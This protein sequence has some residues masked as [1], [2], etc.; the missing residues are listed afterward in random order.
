M[1]Y[2][3]GRAIPVAS[4][5]YRIGY[6]T[7]NNTA[8]DTSHATTNLYQKNRYV[9]LPKDTSERVSIDVIMIGRGAGSGLPNHRISLREFDGTAL[10]SHFT[11]VTEGTTSGDHMEVV[12]G[13]TEVSSDVKTNATTNALSFS[14]YHANN[15]TP[16]AGNYIQVF[17]LMVVA[18]MP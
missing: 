14:L 12:S 2:G 4:F 9:T 16:G 8:E 1:S 11:V 7:V 18:R 10:S 17:A 13:S 5:S 3:V 6:A 15:A